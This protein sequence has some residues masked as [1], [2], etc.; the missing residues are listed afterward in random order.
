M[1]LN[2]DP[3]SVQYLSN[4]ASLN[5]GRAAS[6]NGVTVSLS[7][8]SI[9]ILAAELFKGLAG[10][11]GDEESGEATEKHEESVDLKNVVHPGS[12]IVL[13]GTSGSEGGNSTLADDGTDLARGG[14]DTVRGRSVASREDFTGNDEGSSVGAWKSVSLISLSIS[15]ELCLPKLK[16]N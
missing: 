2:E 13:R 4:L 5:G 7:T 3:L 12:S 9:V 6:F 14:G 11:L 15:I 8:S 1:Q 10:S 16:K